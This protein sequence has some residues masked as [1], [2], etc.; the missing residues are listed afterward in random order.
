MSRAA[1][2]ADARLV[3]AL[4]AQDPH[5]L[6]GAVVRARPGPARDA[7][8]SELRARL[9]EA[10][11][12]RLPAAIGDDRLLGGLDLAATLAARRPIAS[13][14]VL[15]EA[16]GGVILAPMA[17]RLEPGAA[18]RIGAALERGEVAVERDGVA[19]T[20]PAR[21]GL[22]LL[23]EGAS[24]EE[25]APA[26][27]AVKLA[28]RIDL[29]SL[30]L[31]DLIAQ[32]QPQPADGAPANDDDLIEALVAAAVAFGVEALHAPLL[33]LRAARA[34]AALHGRAQ[35]TMA[36]A[37]IAARLVLAPR[38]TQNPL[39]PEEDAPGPPPRQEDEPPPPESENQ[40]GETPT[41]VVLDAV[42]AALPEELLIAAAGARSSAERRR[43]RGEADLSL[44]RGRPAGARPGALE[45]GARLHVVETLRA[46][47]PWQPIRRRAARCEA[48]VHIRKEDF[49]IR[50]FQERKSALTIFAV[51]ASGSA[52]FRRLAE[53]KGAIELMLAKAYVRRDEVALIA[54]RGEGT[55]LLLPP[56][57]SLV[58]AK[59][60]LAEL[61]GGG[62][63]PLAA[64]LDAAMTLAETMRSKGRSVFVAVLTDGRANIARDGRPGRAQATSDALA[65]AR[66]FKAT[67]LPAA[68][69]DVSV[70]PAPEA[71]ALADAMG[72]R[73]APL[74]FADAAAMRATVDR[75]A[76]G[77]A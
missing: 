34:H 37:A 2:W 68:V 36:D 69:L 10:R 56:T 19:L 23:D 32:P 49:R 25:Q 75:L 65:A 52:A 73:Y 18:A 54:F 24:P 47:A 3:A 1:R 43:G 28:F 22:V 63:T 57:R 44:K 67:S 50:R 77:G 41:D 26:S 35:P 6:R 31:A 5:G 42:R 71:Q 46:A 8:L 55:E 33:A 64:G 15:A 60:R 53:A 66:S 7:W 51:D 61:P 27:L 11:L 12:R 29:E 70:R 20:S 76:R 48:P 39:D 72:A 21:F 13:R 45:A 40:N 17:E 62:G 14:G 9:G 4:L 58:R 16:D 74:P 59:R 30:A 38:A